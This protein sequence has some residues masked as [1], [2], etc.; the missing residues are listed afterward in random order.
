[1][2]RKIAGVSL[3]L[4]VTMGAVVALQIEGYGTLEQK[5]KK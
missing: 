2:N 1:M 5:K 4:A 3:A